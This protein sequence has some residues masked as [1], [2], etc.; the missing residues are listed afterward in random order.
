MV[1][2]TG[3]TPRHTLT[4]AEKQKCLEALHRERYARRA[5]KKE[6]RARVAAAASKEAAAEAK[7]TAAEAK[8]AGNDAKAV[9]AEEIDT[10][11]R[12]RR[13]QKRR[14]RR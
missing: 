2:P 1:A 6:E 11:E 14:A 5:D 10:Q 4:P 12:P 13:K 3:K 9:V 7:E 8:A